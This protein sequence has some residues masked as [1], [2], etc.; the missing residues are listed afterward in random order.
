MPAE[1]AR[2]DYV[3]GGARGPL[4]EG[5]A[6]A[7]L[8]D[9]APSGY[10]ALGL[11]V[12]EFDLVF[13]YPWP[14][15]AGLVSDLFEGHAR[16]GALLLTYHVDG[17]LQLRRKQWCPPDPVRDCLLASNGDFGPPGPSAGGDRLSW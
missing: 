12:E 2:G 4:V 14:D 15:E 8:S 7:W 3:P 5:R 10:E 9:A 13:A 11:G 1:F 16:A 6:F 17:Q